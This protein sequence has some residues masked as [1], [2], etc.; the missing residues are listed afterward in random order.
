MV[1]QALEASGLPAR[2]LELE[3]TESVLLQ[4]SEATLAAARTARLWRQDLARRLR[5]RVFLAELPAQLPV[6]QDQ[7]RPF[8]RQRTGNPR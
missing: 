2:R 5:S 6:R 1:K 7:D 8:V 3:I 4:N